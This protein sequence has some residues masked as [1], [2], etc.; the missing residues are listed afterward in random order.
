MIRTRIGTV[1]TTCTGRRGVEECVVE[2]E[3]RQVPALNVFAALGPLVPGER[4]LL[5]TTAVDLQLGT[6]GFHFVMAR[7][8]SEPTEAPGPGHTMKLRYTPWQVRVTSVEERS[9]TDHASLK[10]AATLDGVPVVVCGLHSQALAALIGASGCS[11]TSAYVV[12]DAG[13]LPAGLSRSLDD[14][15]AAGIRPVVITAGH[16]FGGDLEAV[17]VHSALLAARHV[18]GAGLIVVSMGPGVTGTGTLMGH[19]EIRQGEDINAA[20]ALGATVLAVPRLS[21]ADSRPR[22]LGVSHHTLAVL[23]VVTL[24]PALVIMPHASAPTRSVWLGQMEPWD[25][26]RRHRLIWLDPSPALQLL[27]RFPVALRTMGRD[28]DQE[29][30]FFAAATLAGMTAATIAEVNGNEL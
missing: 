5:N 26:S 18:V 4:V 15:S 6:G 19:S 3:G 23:G 1:I 13:A 17:N 10:Q 8:A 20:A 16:A 14:L 22:H 9:G 2:C 21:D 27:G 25:I 12:N 11:A 29:P 30:H 24:A 28:V 7:L